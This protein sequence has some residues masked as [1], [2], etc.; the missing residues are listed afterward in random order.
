MFVMTRSA[1]AQTLSVT[2]IYRLPP[3]GPLPPP[4]AP[5][6]LPNAAKF[7]NTESTSIDDR[8]LICALP[9]CVM[10]GKISMSTGDEISAGGPAGGGGVISG[11]F[12]GPAQATRGSSKLFVGGKPVVRQCDPMMHDSGN[13]SGSALAPAQTL[14]SVAS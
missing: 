12:A 11:K 14:F 8:L 13:A 7:A 10:P 3:P 1:T 5:G 9:A 2:G 4:G 6:P